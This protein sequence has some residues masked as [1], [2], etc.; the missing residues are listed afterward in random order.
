MEGT[1]LI[2]EI[3]RSIQGE[4][5][6]AGR[7]CTLVRLSACNLRCSWCDT[8]HAFYG[9]TRMPRAEVLAKALSHDTPLVELTGGDLSIPI[10]V[11][12]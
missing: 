3:Y 8:T 7:P 12:H 2:H 4:S 9:G 5:S 6:F 1:L 10:E 11:T